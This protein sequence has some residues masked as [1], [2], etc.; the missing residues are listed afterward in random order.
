MS[1]TEESE[2]VDWAG[3]EQE[4][5]ERILRQGEIFVAAQLQAALAADS[6]S[7]VMGAMCI[8]LALAAIAA[9]AAWGEGSRGVPY[10]VSAFVCGMF[11]LLAA[12]RAAWDARPITFYY[13][14]NYPS[15]WWP[16]RDCPLVPILGGEAE[17]YEARIVYNGKELTEN[18]EALEDVFAFAILSPDTRHPFLVARYF[19]LPGLE[20]PGF[21]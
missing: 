21:P 5:V 10:L 1:M 7:T 16:N 14:G 20:L 8:T 2:G 9:G 19:L 11:L 3:T 13:P 18:Q 17:N 4:M 6:R 15:Q 12:Y